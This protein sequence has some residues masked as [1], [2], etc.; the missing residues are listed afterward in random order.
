MPSRSSS[1]YGDVEDCGVT[2]FLLRTRLSR[3]RNGHHDIN[4]HVLSPL[5]SS[6]NKVTVLVGQAPSR[7]ALLAGAG[8]GLGR[9]SL[10]RLDISNRIAL[11][12][13]QPV[14]LDNVQARRS[15]ADAL[16]RARPP[17]SRFFDRCQLFNATAHWNPPHD[18]VTRARTASP[19]SASERYYSHIR[20]DLA[21]ILERA[22]RDLPPGA[23]GRHDEIEATGHGPWP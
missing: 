13:V 19:S 21:S 16:V 10:S 8:P 15:G 7:G 9:G 14:R 18:S 6:Q 1:E 11:P 2:R 3:L 22:Y 17:G 4:P 23:N 20:C 5:L 12:R